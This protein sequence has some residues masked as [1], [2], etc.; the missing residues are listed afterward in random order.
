MEATSLTRKQ[1]LPGLADPLETKNPH[2]DAKK[3][4]ARLHW[5]LF[6]GGSF[7]EKMITS[8]AVTTVIRDN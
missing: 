6:F 3:K 4:F 2:C 7:E 8:T 1:V 5:G